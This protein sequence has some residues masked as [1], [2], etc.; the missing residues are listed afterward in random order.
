M[1]KRKLRGSVIVVLIIMLMSVSVTSYA[2]NNRANIVPKTDYAKEF[3]K[4]CD[5]QNWFIYEVE[6]LLNIEQK[7]ISEIKNKQDFKNIKHIGLSGRMISGAIPRAVGELFNLESLFLSEN[8][9]T[10]KFPTQLFGLDNLKNIDVSSNLYTGNIPAEFGMMKSL[11]SINLRKNK[12]AGEIPKQILENSKISTLDVS[13]NGLNRKPKDFN[14]MQALKYIAISDN[15]FS[16]A[17]MPDT[18]MLNDIKVISMW[19]CNIKGEVPEYIYDKGSLEILDLADNKITGKIDERFSNMHNLEMLSLGKNS[20]QGRIPDIFGTMPKLKILD[21]NHNMLV[22][23]VD[24]N[25]KN[26]SEVHLDGNYLTGDNLKEIGKND[27][28]F[29]DG[30]V[31]PQYRLTLPS[32]TVISKNQKTNIYLLLKNLKNTQ[33]DTD[34]KVLLQP[35]SYEVDILNDAENKVKLT[36]DKNGI[37][38]ETDK[39]ISRE[40]RI[41][42]KIFIKENQGSDYS[43]AA[44]TI[45]TFIPRMSAIMPSVENEKKKET[46]FAYINGYPDKT[47]RADKSVTREEIAKMCIAA[48]NMRVPDKD[49]VKHQIYEDVKISRWSIGYITRTTELGWFKGYGSGKF[50][51]ENH[52]SRAELAACLVRISEQKEPITIKDTT[53]QEEKPALEDG[54]NESQGNTNIT[55]KSIADKSI[56]KFS[57]VKDNKWYTEYI[58]KA[59]SMGLIRGYEDGTFRPENKVKRVEAVL[60]INRMLE[61]N[62]ENERDVIMKLTNPFKDLKETYHS[63]MDIIEASVT[64]EC[65]LH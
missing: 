54:V 21:L 32:F 3:I 59:A 13:S 48:F 10:G 29:C 58:S 63:Y 60:M 36:R 2:E 47:F 30:A 50:G 8:K 45:T 53:I 23:A 26:I 38:I 6:R 31:S 61:R 18:S 15:P 41:E 35:D 33:Q 4:L 11:R 22:G 64:H 52:I 7:T 24:A 27:D 51:P 37:Y 39:D 56:K 40:E 46:H 62:V 34:K 44:T 49:D 12:F 43:T 5:G 19:N 20:M 57:D 14:K 17:G 28:N 9:L 25:I 16:D 42:L 1:I 65:E 55:D